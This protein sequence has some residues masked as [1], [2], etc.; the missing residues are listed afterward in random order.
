MTTS[1]WLL[2]FCLVL[3]CGFGDSVSP[4]PT[5]EDGHSRMLK[6]LAT[7]RD[8]TADTNHFLGDAAV[9]RARAELRLLPENASDFERFRLLSTIGAHELRLGHNDDAITQLRNAYDLLPGLRG[10]LPRK[11]EEATLLTLSIAYLRLGETSNCVHHHTSDSCILPIR[12]GGV[13][14]D[15]TGSRSAVG[16]L[17]SLLVQNPNHLTARW[18]LNIAYMTLGEYP[19][20]VPDT[21]LIPPTAFETDEAFPRFVNIA[22]QLGLNVVSLCGGVVVDDFD[23]DDLLDIVVSSWD[24]AGQVRHFRN[25]GDGRFTDT[26]AAA[27]L[28]GIFGGLNLRQADYDNDGDTD[29]LILRG[30]WLGP[31]GRHPNS[32]LQNNGKGRFRDVTFEV[33][34]GEVHCPTATA[35]WADYD[36]D[37][38]LDLY[39]GNENE[40]CQL[41]ENDGE[42]HFIDVAQ[43]AGVSNGGFTKGVTWGDYD[44]DRFPDLYVSNLDGANRLYHNNRDGTFVDVAQQLGVERPVHS[45]PTWFWDFNNDGSLD[46]FVGSYEATARDV[47]ADYLQL[48][49]DTAPDCLYRGNGK[50]RFVECA[51]ACNLPLVTQPMGCNF[52]DIDDDGYPDFY[53]GTGD[54]AYESLMPNLMFRNVGGERFANVTTAGGFGHLQ[55]GH[56]VAF[57]DLDND[58][59]QDVFIEMGGAFPGDAF[60]NVLFENPGF[61]NNS[62]T[63]RLVGTQSNRSAIGARVRIELTEAGEKRSVYK[64]VGSGSSFSGNPL[65]LEMGIGTAQAADVVEIFWPTTG[66][67]QRFENVSASQF[68]EIHEGEKKIVRQVARDLLAD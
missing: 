35:E 28:N 27:G 49:H 16:Y 51:R 55:K 3:G 11:V 13:H 34:L 54:T 10:Q 47:A 38:D 50:G 48:T 44:G 56:G 6:A 36:N 46:L 37:G 19:D 24:S 4:E 29:I 21:H 63:I 53:L 1:C 45:F 14:Q 57:A 31:A 66:E 18:L 5:V 15:K 43:Q 20:G 52:G 2:I 64:W 39:I 41:F 40:P 30:A 17:Q 25:E 12:A 62:I 26:T 23:G 68:V 9:R 60:G 22:P 61:G 65:R 42:N 8:E 33:G 59:D 7:V 32:L 67:T 58:G